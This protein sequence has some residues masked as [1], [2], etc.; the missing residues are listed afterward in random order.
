MTQFP[1]NIDTDTDLP[2]INSNLTEI[3]D[4]AINS[5]RDATFAIEN[6][7]GTNIA[8][9]ATSLALRLG[10]ALDAAG[11]I[12]ASALT[13]LGLVTLPITQG[14]I[15]ANAGIP[16]S[17]LMLDHRTQDLFNYI[18]DL[19]N[20]VNVAL[21]WISVS[22]SKLEPHLI[23][24]IYRHAL[25]GIDE[26]SDPSKLIK[27]KFGLLRDPTSAFSAVNDMNNELLAHQFADGSP[28]GIISSVTTNN[29]SVYPSNYGHL[30]SG[31]FL[32]SARFQV[33]PQNVQDLQAFAT[34][35]DSA[36]IFLFGTRIQNLYTNG[37]S[38]VSRSSSLAAD[39]YGQPIIP[40]TPAFAHLLNDGYNTSPFDDINA[41]D[42]I[43]EFMPAAADIAS[44]VFDEKFALVK[45]GD[46]IRIN[47]GSQLLAFVIKE[48]KYI[49]SG[50]NKKYVVRIAGKN[51][52]SS[53]NAS[54]R[55]DRPLFNNK[56]QGVLA[57][58]P[59]NNAF[60]EIP[61]LIIGQPRGA[62]AIGVGFN[63]DHL[64]ASH[65]LLY[66]AL[67]PDG[68][69]Q[70]G[71]FI[72]PGI[73][74][75]GNR[76]TT[77]GKYTIDTVVEATNNALRTVGFNYRF[78]AFSYQGEFGIMLAEPY[79]NASFSVLSAV[80]TPNG[81]F[82]QNATNLQFPNNVVGI[83]P[84]GANLVAPDP[85]G[86]GPFGGNIASP[87]FL[88]SY[89]SP[90]ASQV[91]TIIFVPLK[92]NNYYVN[93]I[94]RDSL[95]LD[96][97]Q[98]LDGYGDGYWVATLQNQ[99][100]FPGPFPTGRV[101]TTYRIP[102]D[103]STS[104]LKAGKTLVVQS[105]GQGALLNFGR[106]IIKTVSFNCVNCG[107]TASTTDITVYDSVHA[108]GSSPQP[109]LSL[110]SKVAIYF[111]SDSVSFNKESA[112]DFSVV[113]PFKRH[114]EVY[115]NQDGKTF[116]HERARI[117]IGNSA[118]TING[119]VTLA[120]YSEL[121][122]LNIVK[123]SPKLRGYLFSSV[124]KIA[125]N[126]LSF[127]GVLGDFNGYL[128]TFDGTNFTRKGPLTFGR[129][130]QTVRFLD[131]TNNDY[132]DIVFD[133][134][135]PV[136]SFTNQVIEF[137]LFPTLSLDD[138]VM[139]IGTCQFN[140]VTLTVNQVRDE[141]QFGNTS[142]KDLSSSAINF[143]QLPEK[144]FH[145]NGVINGFDLSDASPNP[146]NGQIYLLGGGV[147]VNGKVKQ[148]GNETVV[149]PM[150]NES[151]SNVLYNINWLL[152]INDQGEYQP[153]PLLDFD[154]ALAT[155]NS[156]DRLMKVFNPING[157][158]Y[159]LDA[160]TFSDVIN[161]RKDLVPIYIVASTVNSIAQTISVQITDVRRYI[162]D[163]DT[164]FPL[165][166]TSGNSQGNFK[167][168]QAII[169]W[170]K[171]NNAFNG[172]AD[173]K[174]ATISSGIISTSLTLD[175]PNTVLIEGENNAVLTFNG[176]V[177]IGSNII[178]KDMTI[179]FNGGIAVKAASQNITFDNCQIV[180]T[181][182]VSTP[183][184]GNIIFDF[185][186][187]NAILIRNCSITINY[188]SAISGGAVFNLSNTSKFNFERNSV[189]VTFI[190]VPGGLSG[191]SVT[192]GDVFD[193]ANS[194]NVRI[195]ESQF[196]GN[197]N[198][199]IF[200]NT[201]SGMRVINSLVQSTYN[202]GIG[203]DFGYDPTDL[204]NSGQGYIYSNVSSTLNDLYLD[205]VTFNY[206]PAIVAS[207]RFSFINL[208]LSNPTSVLNGLTITNCKF[209]HINTDT[210]HDDL[211]PAVSIINI[212]SATNTLLAQPIVLN[213]KIS[214]NACNRN[215]S[216]MLTSKTVSS[217]MRLP[218]LVTQNVLIANNVCGTIGYWVSVGTKVVNIVP[219][220][221]TSSDKN[222]ELLIVGNTCHD[223]TNVDHRGQYFMVARLL[224]GGG[225]AT[226]NMVGYPSGKVV[227][228][229][230]SAN[231]VH[232]GISQE[233]DASLHITNNNLS[234]YDA[235]YLANYGD[236]Q[237]NSTSSDNIGSYGYAIFVGADKHSIPDVASPGEGSDSPSII[238][239]NTVNTGYWMLPSA[240]SFIYNYPVG[241]IYC[242]S[243]NTIT[244]NIL[245]GA[246]G[247]AG[248]GA[249]GHLI[250]TSGVFNYVAQNKIF[251]GINI[252]TSYVGF[253]NY[254]V[255][256]WD[257]TG[258]SGMV[259]DNFFDSP[260]INPVTLD[261]NVV[262]FNITPVINSLRWV[263]ERNK[264]QTGYASIPI[265]NSQ[266]I[267]YGGFGFATFDNNTLFLTTAPGLGLGYKSQVLN[268]QDS[269]VPNPR[270]FGWQENLDK[271]LPIGV[272]V[273]LIKM[274]M[275]SFNSTVETK[276]IPA[277][278][279]DS[280]FYLFL[281][282]YATATSYT[283]LDYFA[284]SS[285]PDSN[286][287][288][289]VA[290]EFPTNPLHAA[291][292]TGGQSNA[293]G[294]TLY[295]TIDTTTAGA[296]STDIS[297]Q[298]ITGQGYAF[299]VSLDIRFK[300]YLNNSTLFFSPLFVKYR[301]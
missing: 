39:G 93:G 92:R 198:R 136:A 248:G 160:S 175:F 14:Q 200:N 110:G 52:F 85:L 204:I 234:A 34:F 71:Y 137:Q 74:V 159:F 60:S 142:E 80:V 284:V 90:Q 235:N 243:S 24:A 140:D 208:E 230:N 13:S 151:F 252:I 291:I 25:D 167:N 296:S 21:G 292:I 111:N 188:V 286:I 213:A 246:G 298:F 112:T 196:F 53:R 91:P 64:D 161:K 145:S 293:T 255:P 37:I 84:V 229:N 3:G 32:N 237:S 11:N 144:L 128:S 124:T 146:D 102:L 67:Y 104:N 238:S 4:I 197:F 98:A 114:F 15:A 180:Y 101:E 299:S 173:V 157:Q 155:P 36:S 99:N 7:L 279:F 50:G 82:D 301:W 195:S 242:Q 168:P 181:A 88:T 253:F 31:I 294:F 170:I 89:G 287:L 225:G 63:A 62:Q 262:K 54:A 35:I 79:N 270:F 41:G 274:G 210:A 72:L 179:N 130:G 183:P 127:D 156:P 65:Y 236:T 158:T 57:I 165:K 23:G 232:V 259:V 261:E 249:I 59:A 108:T 271:Y 164:N 169:N 40:P 2:P 61:S 295:M 12:K 227:I 217:R 220:V 138:E 103:L 191:P 149:I 250:L 221:N 215:Q 10:V 219:N 300:R 56:K 83:F 30:A 280:N 275:R 273:V 152:C 245:K 222:T 86:F 42:D 147:L 125:L 240:V 141:R 218:G 223:I 226:T 244:K 106:F 115:V 132:I 1:T 257:G 87:P 260:F 150:V 38:R 46:I 6:A 185:T 33:I 177:T 123:V 187:G 100:I 178:F 22:G 119:N 51:P 27:N 154:P 49:Q 166:L 211:R 47:Y 131:E 94:E 139:L 176:L 120:T 228:D 278:G 266:L 135:A 105:L 55:I 289:D 116:T 76:G 182:P 201:S 209:N 251:R 194:L 283:N 70:D 77:P 212:A 281:N 277:N 216:I 68:S 153:I 16:E 203:L 133:I 26:I 122:K 162:T 186:S 265:T 121:A 192:P 129:K 285:S 134:N 205:N 247:P 233:E 20:N 143:I 96:I 126:I 69:P 78:I 288:N 81:A 214:N 267:L 43:V 66:L 58:A 239:G 207:D 241:Y 263:V 8:G 17:K 148:L 18:R 264:N 268:I 190:I 117:N 224:G 202:P 193:I 290:L 206:N 269:D 9:S 163:A 258:A 113:S 19:S 45:I 73:D 297:D 272:R 29:G 44:N 172:K 5:L 276:T 231:W 282:K 184:P 171:Y 118:A 97:G 75:T 48:K 174:G 109:T 254:E 189:T 107:G 95:A 256:T 28:F 199:F